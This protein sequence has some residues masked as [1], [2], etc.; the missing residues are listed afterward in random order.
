MIS[1]PWT[2]LNLMNSEHEVSIGLSPP[3]MSG[4]HC[5]ISYQCLPEALLRMSYRPRPFLL[6]PRSVS[7]TKVS[8]LVGY[9]LWH[10]VQQNS[11]DVDRLLKELAG[12]HKV[13]Y[14]S[15][16]LSKR[17][18]TFQMRINSDKQHDE[19][20]KVAVHESD[21]PQQN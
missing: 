16:D 13:L 1:R 8:Q 20:F 15:C 17:E 21:M 6:C 18:L 12:F 5:G 7:R 3:S 14:W 10:S 11:C 19:C 4:F 9:W 2:K